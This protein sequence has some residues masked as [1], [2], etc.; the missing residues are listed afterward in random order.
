M[1]NGKRKEL[2][3]SQPKITPQ[4]FAA[5]DEFTRADSLMMIKEGVIEAPPGYLEAIEKEKEALKA[6]EKKKRK[7]FLGIF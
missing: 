4:E 3:L 5:G 1:S 7:R 6:E 2:I